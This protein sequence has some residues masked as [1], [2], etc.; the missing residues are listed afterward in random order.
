MSN[1][2]L[3]YTTTRNNEPGGERSSVIKEKDTALFARAV[4][5][6]MDLTRVENGELNHFNLENMI[7]NTKKLVLKKKKNIK[8]KKNVHAIPESV[9][10]F[11]GKQ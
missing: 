10:F 6:M 8:I 1:E 5:G 2:N 4:D 11:C 9:D 3:P 7:D